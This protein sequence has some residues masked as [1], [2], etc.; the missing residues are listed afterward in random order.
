[1]KSPRHK[2]GPKHG[3]GVDKADVMDLIRD[4]WDRGLGSSTIAE[5]IGYH[6]SSVKHYLKLMDLRPMTMSTRVERILAHLPVE[7]VE[8]ARVI[9]AHAD[10]INASAPRRVRP[11]LH[12]DSTRTAAQGIGVL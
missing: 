9:K 2:S 4:L 5:L 8:R 11:G 3:C 6:P 12:T 1:M 10:M 7:H